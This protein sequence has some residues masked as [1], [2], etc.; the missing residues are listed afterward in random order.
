MN[1]RIIVLLAVFAWQ[2][3][4]V[5]AQEI[6][7]FTLK[8]A[9]DFALKNNSSIKMSQNDLLSARMKVRETTA[10]GLPQVKGNISYKDFIKQ[11]VSLVPAEFFGGQEGTFAEIT[12]GTEQ[13][14][15]AEIQASQLV[16]DGSYIVGLQTTKTFLE[17]SKLNLEKT[18]LD[19]EKQIAHSYATA[20]LAEKSREILSKNIVFMN[21]NLEETKEMYNKGILDVQDVEQL[22]LMVSEM[23]NKL[24][25]ADR[26][27]ALSYD[28]LKLNMGLK[29]NDSIRLSDS[30][31]QLI[32]AV[33]NN[34]NDSSL[35]VSNNVE[36]K[37]LVAQQQLALLSVKNEKMKYFPNVN[38][39]ISHQ[40]NAYRNEF[41]FFDGKFDWFPTTVW[42]INVNVPIFSSFMR[43][44]RVQQA[45]LQLE[46]V[47][48]NKNE[49]SKNLTLSEMLALSNL[50]KAISEY[51]NG[52]E[53]LKLA[54]RIRDKTALKYKEGMAS[55]LQLSQSETQ[56]LSVQNAY[57]L[58]M[59]NMFN[60]KA[61][62]DNILGKH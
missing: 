18:E 21:A 58:S 57:V 2:M 20:L 22:Q 27:L 48:L 32:K 7:S 26:Q 51:N 10:I 9:K 38:A 31:D 61:E 36:Y 44:A 39:F 46:N 42:G 6:K 49:I 37:L 3:Y 43:N 24:D 59:F 54:E 11:P 1:C 41:N 40:E 15:T 30:F 5:S 14:A 25:D 45:K 53:N 23:R 52:K 47:S 35:A 4:C 19:I 12:F 13:N 8:E 16:F 56:L 28:M 29:I 62:L 33:E 55:S 34:N 50:D 60:A 17:L